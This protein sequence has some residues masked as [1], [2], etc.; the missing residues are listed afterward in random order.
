LWRSA[1]IHV[2]IGIRV[3]VAR[4]DFKGRFQG[5]QGESTL[6]CVRD[7]G[8]WGLGFKEHA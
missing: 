8:G 7:A 6:C 3:L 4:C 2:V 5:F 1:R